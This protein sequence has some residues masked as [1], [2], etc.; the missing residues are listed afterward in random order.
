MIND[1]LSAVSI[2]LDRM[3]YPDVV[4]TE[5]WNLVSTPSIQIAR[6]GIWSKESAFFQRIKLCILPSFM[7]TSHLAATVY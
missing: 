1:E 4:V 6:L 3:F 7:L 2:H 5:A